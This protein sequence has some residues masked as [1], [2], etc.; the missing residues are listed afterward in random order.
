MVEKAKYR[1]HMEG[2][3]YYYISSIYRE[4][5]KFGKAKFWIKRSKE[6]LSKLIVIKIRY[7]IEIHVCICIEEEFTDILRI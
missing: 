5:K 7:F 1:Q 6:V 4:K 3:I 2:R